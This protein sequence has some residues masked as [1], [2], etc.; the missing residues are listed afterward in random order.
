MRPSDYPATDP[1]QASKNPSK[2]VAPGRGGGKEDERNAYR[3]EGDGERSAVASCRA[4]ASPR[5]AMRRRDPTRCRAPSSRT[6]L[7]RV[8][9]LTVVGI[10]S[11][12][13]RIRLRSGPKSRGK[14]SD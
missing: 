7:L 6:A 9:C 11:R 10:S 8:A 12:R 13:R 14:G 3:R 5:N 4:V 1:A 2:N